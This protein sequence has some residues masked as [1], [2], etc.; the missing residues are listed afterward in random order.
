MIV[1][2]LEDICNVNLR[3]SGFPSE[4]IDNDPQV[5]GFEV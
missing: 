1:K 5:E 4:L 3:A 2:R